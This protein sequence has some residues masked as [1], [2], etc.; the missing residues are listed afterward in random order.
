MQAELLSNIGY[1]FGLQ[2]ICQCPVTENTPIKTNTTISHH[3]KS[4]AGFA[5]GLIGFFVVALSALE[6]NPDLSL[7]LTILHED[8]ENVDVTRALRVRLSIHGH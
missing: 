6:L 8:I 3:K 7:V 4:V 1:T 2:I 5:A